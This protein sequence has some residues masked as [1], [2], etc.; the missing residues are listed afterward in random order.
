M[1]RLVQLPEVST[2]TNGQL[3]HQ[4]VNF[5]AQ[6]RLR[7]LTER[8]AAQIDERMPEL[9][10]EAK[11]RSLVLSRKRWRAYPVRDGAPLTFGSAVDE[12]GTVHRR[13]PANASTRKPGTCHQWH[14]TVASCSIYLS[15]RFRWSSTPG[16]KAV[17]LAGPFCVKCKR[18]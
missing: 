5:R 1:S 15:V 2:L 7:G 13:V 16:A 9:E 11:A 4:W 6:R 18:M 10:A 12:D 3:V 14:R 8:L 17:R